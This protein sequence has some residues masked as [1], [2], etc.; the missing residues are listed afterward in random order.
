MKTLIVVSV[1]F[2]TA[3][4][5]SA[6]EPTPAS[7]SRPTVSDPAVPSPSRT[8]PTSATTKARLNAGLPSFRS[9]AKVDAEATAAN[10]AERETDVPRNGIIRL[11]QYD[12]REDKIPMFRER[13]LLTQKGRADVAL[14]RHPG[15][16]FGPLSFLNVRRGLEMLAEEDELDR[17]REMA[18]LISFRADVESILPQEPATGPRTVRAESDSK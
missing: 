9:P 3:L 13:E 2:S 17:R 7:E 14:R 1:L 8:P 4:L 10:P 15:L 16:R 11:P 6:A 12:V 18:K 5:T